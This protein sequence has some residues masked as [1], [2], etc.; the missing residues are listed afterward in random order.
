MVRLVI[1]LLLVLSTLPGAV[2]P[3]AG[4]GSPPVDGAA[5]DSVAEASTDSLSNET[6]S[7]ESTAALTSGTSRQQAAL[8]ESLALTTT[9]RLTPNR[10]GEVM[11]TLRYDVPPSVTAVETHVPANATVTSV[12]DFAQTERSDVRYE[13]QEA[14]K[15]PSLTYRLPV[16]ET[17]NGA[18][19]LASEGTYLFAD[20]GPWALFRKPNTGTRWEWRGGDV[21]L[22]KSTA[23]D[24]SGVVG[25]ELVLLGPYTEHRRRANDQQ[26]R[27]VVPE[28]ATLTEEPSSIL[29]S[30]ADASGRLR[31]GD[32]DDRVL[33]IAAPTSGVEWG[34]RGLQTGD[35]DIW[36]RD[37]EPLSTPNN[38]WLHE[39]VHSRQ[40]FRATNETRWFTEGGAT[41]YAGLLTLQQGRIG[42]DAF[43]SW[44]SLG[45][46]EPVNSTVLARPSTWGRQGHYRKGALVAGYLDYRIRV[47]SNG[48][49][50]LDT[51]LEELNGHDGAVTGEAFRT[52]VGAAASESNQEGTDRSVGADTNRSVHDD[53]DRFVTT[54]AAPPTWTLSEH[55]DAFGP[56]A[57]HFDARFGVNAS[58]PMRVSGPYREL[59][60][61]N[62]AGVTLVPNETLRLPVVVRNNGGRAA[63]YDIAIGV[64]GTTEKR[65]TGRLEP[66][67]RRVE[68]V[69]RTFEGTGTHT[70][71][72]G[73]EEFTVFVR[74]PAEP[75][76]VD[77][78]VT[79]TRVAANEPATVSATVENRD[80]RPG[81]TV[82]R[83]TVD[84]RV[85][86]E[87]RV[88]LDASEK[89]TVSTTVRLSPGTY[90]VGA[91][92]STTV[93]VDVAPAEETS[94]ATS[95]AVDGNET[96]TSPTSDSSWVTTPGFGVVA[97]LVALMLTVGSTAIATRLR[98]R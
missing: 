27:L 64:D 8:G 76:V 69:V 96:G 78:S 35:A 88:V 56:F 95:T 50:S 18:L 13:W 30:Y 20:A 82:V 14:T 66:G 60:V 80:S 87:K 6:D 11:V 39:Y 31:V 34:V 54:R 2:A 45:L 37:S 67:E 15:S 51:V 61:T 74:E 10:P 72:V 70:I 16:N 42:Y 5:S 7:E 46:Q 48:G 98:P 89:A 52:A 97:T 17:A 77:V 19:P 33:V 21:G 68:F 90:R 65:L 85:V 84:D 23:V 91:R 79:P 58:N 25:E 44:L 59:S 4:V 92:G 40:S 57:A 62:P 63:S 86:D 22:A 41:Y 94:A 28:A 53:V 9:F 26:F 93:E 49:S 73:G 12:E 71:T 75:Q 43:E 3:V 36:V 83:F 29:D 24:G 1:A 32:R 55:I 38:V 47:A 81:A